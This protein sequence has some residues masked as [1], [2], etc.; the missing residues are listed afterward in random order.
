MSRMK[1]S[2]HTL[3][4]AIATL[5]PALAIAGLAANAESTPNLRDGDVDAGAEIYE[6]ECHGCHGVS[7]APTLRGVIGREAA[8]VESFAVY[9]EALKAKRP[10]TWTAENLNAF[11]TSPQEFIPGT[12]MTKIVADPQARADLI[13][14]IATLP[15]PR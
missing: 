7:I 6:A 5:A 13:A 9:S 1:H 8:S 3:R 10:M 11:L 15:P 2:L 4:F 14:F 12:Q